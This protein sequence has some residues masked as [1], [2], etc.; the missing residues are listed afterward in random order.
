ML[1]YNPIEECRLQSQI[2]P[3]GHSCA[4]AVHSLLRTVHILWSILVHS[5][6][7]GPLV[8]SLCFLYILH[9]SVG[10]VLSPQ[11]HQTSTLTTFPQAGWVCSN[12]FLVPYPC[13][14]SSGT[15]LLPVICMHFS[16]GPFPWPA[17]SLGVYIHYECV[18]V[19]PRHRTVYSCLFFPCL[20]DLIV[21]IWPYYHHA[22]FGYIEFC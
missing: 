6:T 5:T 17:T 13:I 1:Y 21:Y 19:S 18:A 9:L 15:A 14:G 12:P 11:S 8:S 20:L 7:W 10:H 3:P 22:R 2:A 16:V 4:L